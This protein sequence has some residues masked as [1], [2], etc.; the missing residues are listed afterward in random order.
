MDESICSDK[1][2][3]N[4]QKYGRLYGWDA[5][6]KACP[7]GWRLPT[8]NDWNA[9]INFAGGEKAAGKKLKSKAGWNNNGN[10][11]DDFGFSALPGG[12]YQAGENRDTGEWMEGGFPIGECGSWQSATMSV[13]DVMGGRSTWFWYMSKDNNSVLYG[14]DLDDG[15][16]AGAHSVRCVQ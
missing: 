3:A 6:M 8:N 11:T 1:K 13:D 5:A 7:A 15:H 9:L 12:N 14:V 16:N 10:G 4:C 2:E